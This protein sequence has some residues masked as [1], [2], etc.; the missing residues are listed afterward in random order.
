MSLVSSVSMAPDRIRWTHPNQWIESAPIYVLYA[1][2]CAHGCIHNFRAFTDVYVIHFHD[3]KQRYKIIESL[4]D[5]LA[6]GT[7]SP[8]I[9]LFDSRTGLPTKAYQY[10]RLRDYLKQ[11]CNCIVQRLMF[12]VDIILL[13]AFPSDADQRIS[14]DPPA[15]NPEQHPNVES[16][17]TTSC[18][19]RLH[20]DR[21]TAH[22]CDPIYGTFSAAVL[23][24]SMATKITAAASKANTQTQT[25][26]VCD[27]LYAQIQQGTIRVYK[28][29]HTNFAKA[30][31]CK[32]P[33]DIASYT[34][35][36][37]LSPSILERAE[38][39]LRHHIKRIYEVCMMFL[40]ACL[41]FCLAYFEVKVGTGGF[42]PIAILSSVPFISSLYRFLP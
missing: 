14:I 9:F 6:E 16:L 7:I 37:T 33:Q 12:D 31:Y 11:E 32:A 5:K 24:K 36:S 23:T 17:S 35:A 29:V 26:S 38:K 22:M 20:G 18:L 27:Q 30:T 4:I 13:Q 15:A 42:I 39:E 34:G 41:I 2:Q 25:Q 8:V 1:T 28:H 21:N 19:Q 40:V 10:S 3:E